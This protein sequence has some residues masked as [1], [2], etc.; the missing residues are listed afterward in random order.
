MFIIRVSSLGLIGELG[1]QTVERSRCLTQEWFQGESNVRAATARNLYWISSPITEI[2]SC[3]GATSATRL[4]A[5]RKVSVHCHFTPYSFC[6]APVVAVAA[7]PVCLAFLILHSGEVPWQHR[8]P[9]FGLACQGLAFCMQMWIPGL[10]L[11][12]SQDTAGIY[13]G[14]PQ[15]RWC[16]YFS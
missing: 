5:T 11:I 13:C 10:I 3:A 1:R 16:L 2:I 9:P 7:S 15:S 8:V 14:V 4:L 6:G 12:G